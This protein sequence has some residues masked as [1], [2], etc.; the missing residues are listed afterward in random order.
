MARWVASLDFGQLSIHTLYAAGVAVRGARFLLAQ[1]ES[2]TC[3]RELP[4]EPPARRPT[5]EEPIV[6]R[7]CSRGAELLGLRLNEQKTYSA[8][9]SLRRLL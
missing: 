3:P 4:A 2:F 9:R 1:A 7:R 6:V 8:Q 5:A